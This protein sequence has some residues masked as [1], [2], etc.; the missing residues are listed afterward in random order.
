MSHRVRVT[1]VAA[2]GALAAMCLTPNPASA[3]T[4][5]DVGITKTHTGHFTVGQDGTFTITLHN[6]GPSA[7]GSDNF[8]VTDT[9]PSGLTYASDTGSNANLSCSPSGQQVT[10]TGQPGIANGA[11][12][13]FTLTVH[14]ANAARPSATNSVAYSESFEADNDPD[15]D[16]DTD[17]VIVDPAAS[18]SPTPGPT[19]PS[20]SPS[21]SPVA[22]QSSS[23]SPSPSAAVAGENNQKLPST[24]FPAPLLLLLAVALVVGGLGVYLAVTA[25]R[26]AH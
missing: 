11:D 14:V 2:M 19:S 8:T 21:S 4:S 18:A 6:D 12:A 16:S 13:S 23:A 26:R 9:L 24:G 15:N 5:F 25:G 10:C 3:G 1:V 22:T 7:T 20:P 17:N